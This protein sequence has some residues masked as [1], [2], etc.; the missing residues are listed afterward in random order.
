MDVDPQTAAK[1]PS[2]LP[3]SPVTPPATS[4][5]DIT[6]TGSA[7]SPSQQPP[8][9][10]P[11]TPQNEPVAS[12][13]LQPT[14]DEASGSGQVAEVDQARQIEPGN[15]QQDSELVK[16][17]GDV[18]LDQVNNQ[19]ELVE[20][21]PDA[22]AASGQ[23]GEEGHDWAPDGDH[24]LKRVKVYELIGSKWVDQ[25]TAFCFGQFQEETGEALLIA[26]AERNYNEVIL[27]TVIRCNDVY[28]RQQDTLIVWTEPDGVD[29][30]LSFQ[31]PEGCLEVWSF[32]LEVQRHMNTADDQGLIS[33][34]PIPGVEGS[35]TANTIMRTGHLPRPQ[36]GIIP[37]IERAIKQLARTQALKDRICEY[38]QQEEYFK[39]LIEVMH[40]AE[41]IES[42]ENLHAL[43]SITQTIL[44][45]NDH[46][47]YEHV[48]EDDIFFGVVGMLEYDPEFP[49][50]KANYRDFL[51]Q[52]THFHQPIPIREPAIQR[53]VHHTYRLQFLKDVVLAR[54]LDDSTFNVLNSCII[55]NQIDIIQHVQHEPNFLREVVRL[56]V[57][58][59]MLTSGKRQVP[60][61]NPPPQPIVINLNGAGDN[62]T[63]E[64]PSAMD[65]DHPPITT[66][67]KPNGVSPA[68]LHGPIPPPTPPAPIPSKRSGAYAFA[69]PE[70]MS[71]TDI[72]L[73]REVILL[74]QHLCVMGKNVQ[75]PARMA[76]FRTLVDRGIL[77]A[78]QW[79]MGLPEQAEGQDNKPMI[80]AG[81]E[82]LAA[83]LDHD[84]NGVRGH[85]LKQ[86]VAIEKERE[87][88]K[89]GADQAETVL[90]MVCRITAQSSDL[91]VQ[92]QVG[93]ALKVWMD[94]PPAEPNTTGGE[95]TPPAVLAARLANGR[96]DDPGTE[97]Y[98]DY[99]Y[100]HCA[101]ILFKPLM[102]L[103]E[104]KQ[105]TDPVFPLTREQTNRFLYLCDL[106]Y[107][108][109]QQHHFRGHFYILS[110]GIVTR[111]ATLL[112]SRDK[113]LRHAS[114]RIFRLL[115]KQNNANLNN[116]V[117]KH[118]ILKPILDLTLLESRRDNLLSC[119]CQ[120]Y[121]ES[122]RKDN[123]KEM[124]KFC[125]TRHETEIRKLAETPLGGQRFELLIRRYEMYNE[126][127]PVETSPEQQL[128]AK[129]A[130]PKSER[131][132]DAEE[133]SYFNTDD[134][135]EDDTNI[136]SISQ[137]WTR[138]GAAGSPTMRRKRRM[139]TSSTT[140]P[141]RSPLKSPQAPLGALLDYGE[142]DD[143]YDPSLQTVPSQGPPQTPSPTLSPK[144]PHL[145]TIPP[146]SPK[147]AH[148]QLSI[149][150]KHEEED[151]DDEDRELET[152]FQSKSSSTP[153]MMAS[154][155]SLRPS[156]KR[157]RGDDDDDDELL[158]RL[159]KV[160]KSD[161]SL[162]KDG[163]MS[164]TGIGMGL[165]MAG[166][167]VNAKLGDES[168]QKKPI[169]LKFGAVSLG[170][171]G[172]GTTTNSSPNPTT[173][174]DTT[175]TTATT[176]LSQTPPVTV[177]KA[178][179]GGGST[180]S[181][182]TPAPTS[183]AGVKDGDTG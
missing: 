49:E 168:S 150:P 56:F 83:L 34:S 109:V 94:L 43:C 24:E 78:V 88:K 3:S 5:A 50:F 146:L 133:E 140:K 8:L 132:V 139:F 63:P 82:V 87:L 70:D 104:W 163:G 29:Y 66:S 84:L 32:I 182:P 116:I 158:A 23:A 106:L 90:E 111:I 36:L 123:M 67:P 18:I 37:D 119:S 42:L 154:L 39:A 1:A 61:P 171:V 98:M 130:W 136:P 65:V 17:E 97:R 51:N 35:I 93:D 28:Q 117:M 159:T 12:S 14:P 112:K 160:K 107:N 27:S 68:A 72:A 15:E 161:P 48:L 71:P 10:P 170:M 55:F 165:G 75:L 173:G 80:S 102:D 120:E 19:I 166:R 26:R 157:R 145:N 172:V 162:Q 4:T 92:C 183:E 89:R 108:F 13:Q 127:L 113:H 122:M 38:I 147:L 81:G 144:S 44:M 79:A 96:K 77:F 64:D 121:F 114:F 149:L 22:V 110:S 6:P 115:L 45:L 20:H 167:N 33:S 25:G 2:F 153:G 7:D 151:E 129:R 52:I 47:L 148:R 126:P 105:V 73:R 101:H 11:E 62:T 85:V 46:G 174:A 40:T 178:S 134:D 100:K 59:E 131:S 155:T 177:E 124:I 60:P 21:T 103:P 142:E 74:L 76:L 91:A 175:G 30:A 141:F 16:T 137:P 58:E 138:T 179:G 181:S 152:L 57:D 53:K 54:V 86:V 176:T 143:D 156:E 118:D 95:A 69:P 169:K 99:F 135:E 128:P 180:T 9:Q 125:M 164:A 31:D 41:D